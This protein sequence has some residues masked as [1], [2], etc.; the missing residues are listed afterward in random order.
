MACGLSLVRLSCPA[1][2]GIVVPR[3][4]IEPQSPALESRFSTPGPPGKSFPII[5]SLPFLLLLHL[6]DGLSHSDQHSKYRGKIFW[7]FPIFQSRRTEKRASGSQRVS[8][9]PE[10]ERL[11]SILGT[12][13]SSTCAGHTHRSTAKTWRA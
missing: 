9:N 4:G 7:E 12:Y 3:P 6:K 11:G 10:E 8:G 2:C 13:P 1:T 5:F